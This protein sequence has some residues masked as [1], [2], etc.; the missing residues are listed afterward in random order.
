MQDQDC[1]S[2]ATLRIKVLEYV[3]ATCGIISRITYKII[4][5]AVDCLP[6]IFKSFS[7]DDLDIP[8][9]LEKNGNT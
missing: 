9:V 3:I 4:H 7:F 6:E 2:L 5:L 1:P 8:K